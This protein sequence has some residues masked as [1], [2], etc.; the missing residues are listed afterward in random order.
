MKSR[1][2]TR[3]AFTVIELLVV[4]A[5][6]LILLAMLIPGTTKPHM[7]AF[8]TVC[9]NNLRQLQQA[10][11]IY[12]YDWSHEPKNTNATRYPFVSWTDYRIPIQENLGPKRVPS[13]K[14]SVFACPKDTF[15]YPMNSKVSKRIAQPLHE[16]SNYVFTSYAYNAGHTII[17]AT[18]N[19]PAKT[20]FH[21][22]AGMKLDSVAHPSKTVLLAEFAALAPFSWHDPQHS[23]LGDASRF[24]NAQDMLAFVDG[25]VAYAKMYYAGTN[26]AWDYN[27]PAGYDYQWSGD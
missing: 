14:D 9:I 5:V 17:P 1:R 23:V 26:L 4:A 27:P 20:N 18:G 2:N 13:P 6:I 12:L 10:T 16:Q 15:Y 24:N 22:L 3:N 11:G 8:K 7:K 19:N 25:H 21:G